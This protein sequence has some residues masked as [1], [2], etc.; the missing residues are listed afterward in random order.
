[1]PLACAMPLA[2]DPTLSIA[3]SIAGTERGAISRR[4]KE[5]LTVG[6]VRDM[7]LG[8]P[9][10]SAAMRLLRKE[11]PHAAMAANA[12]LYAVDVTDIIT[13]NVARTSCC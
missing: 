13:D 5:A 7:K 11:D 12:N 6:R 4:T 9:H 10:G 3:L 1:M 2:N 8:N